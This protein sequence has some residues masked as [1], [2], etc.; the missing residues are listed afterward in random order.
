MEVFCS[1]GE[2]ASI[3][4]HQLIYAITFDATVDDLNKII[5]IHPALQ[6]ITI[7][8]VRTALENFE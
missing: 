6:E 4:I 3:M 1:I 2:E 7:D 5:Y 8:S